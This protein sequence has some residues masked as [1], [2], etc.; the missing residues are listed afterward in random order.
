MRT[1]RI[2]SKKNNEAYIYLTFPSITM[3]FYQIYLLTYFFRNGIIVTIFF[4]IGYLSLIFF[5]MG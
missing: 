5:G 2:V 4:G 1:I 3:L